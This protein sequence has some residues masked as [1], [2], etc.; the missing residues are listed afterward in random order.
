MGLPPEAY[1][2][3]DHWYDFLSNGWLEWHPQD[4]TGYS[5]DRMSDGQMKQV[6]AFLEANYPNDT[7]PYDAP[8]AIPPMTGWLRVRLGLSAD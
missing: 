8:D 1:L 2:T 7:A 6:L 4:R 5:F 3:W